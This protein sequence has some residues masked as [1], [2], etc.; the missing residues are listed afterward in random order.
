MLNRLRSLLL[1]GIATLPVLPV[2]G[3]L[4]LVSGSVLPLHAQTT[5][6]IAGTVTDT[7]GAL[8][9]GVT[10]TARQQAT[11]RV[12]SAPTGDDG[13][14]VLSLLPVGVWELR[15]ELQGFRPLVRTDIATSSSRL[16]APARP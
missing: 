14:Y 2:S 13:R 3:S 16:Q 12:R 15:A 7:S 8:L 4:L 9:P 1:S 6:T 5:S 10:V 11:G